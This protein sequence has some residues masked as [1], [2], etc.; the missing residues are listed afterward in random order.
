MGILIREFITN[1]NLYA[2]EYPMVA[3][4]FSIWALGTGTFILKSFPL[5]VWDAFLRTFTTKLTLLNTSDSYHLFLKWYEENNFSKN[6]R[7]IKIS[8]GRWGYEDMVK[9]MGY[10]N[11]YF[12]FNRTPIKLKLT[13]KESVGSD[14]ERDQIEMT[15]LG[16]SHST[17]NKIFE[18]IRDKDLDKGKVVI[19]KYDDGW[20]RVS[21]QR[22]RSIETIHLNVGKKEEIIK[23][24]EEFKAREEFNI[25]HGIGH[26]TA[27]MLH[28]PPGTGKTSIILALAGH[29]NMKIHNLNASALSK[30]EGAF[31]SLPENSLIVIED[32]D[33][34]K[35]LHC[36][37]KQEEK[38]EVK[39]N[40]MKEDEVLNNET[41]DSPLFSFTN[42]SDVLNAIQGLHSSHGRILIAT[43]NHFDRLDEALIR[44]GRFNLKTK[45]DYADNYVASQFV[46]R[47]F[48]DNKLPEGFQV[49]PNMPSS[50]IEKE[51]L[52]NLD[53]F[54]NFV[55]AIAG[56]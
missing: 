40:T 50:D 21:E 48:P 3:G 1:F 47:F 14:R 23:F 19:H 39:S 45:I 28:G 7:S 4:G 56:E 35:M 5:K 34:D 53:S 6:S 10:G 26:Q 20:R 9:A 41:P 8:N 42:M 11:H 17:Y 24:I 32:I 38:V 18:A 27:I 44:S 55:Q 29:F 2:K 43:T 12:V 33:S 46:E 15:I 25:K 37:G 49:R 31:A 22:K 54:D 36:R 16:R 52:D 13:E 30:I 51:V